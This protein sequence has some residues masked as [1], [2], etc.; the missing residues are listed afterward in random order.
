ML[1]AVVLVV[2]ILVVVAIVVVVVV[3]VALGL[4]AAM[5]VVLTSSGAMLPRSL[6]HV[7]KLSWIT[8][9]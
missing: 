7:R 3:I 5:G 9:T 2:V 4:V 6:I 8:F 1:S